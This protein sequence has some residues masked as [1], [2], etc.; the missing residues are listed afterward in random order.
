MSGYWKFAAV[1]IAATTLFSACNNRTILDLYPPEKTTNTDKSIP[2]S[3]EPVYSIEGNEFTLK[4][5]EHIGEEGTISLVDNAMGDLNADGH[6]DQAV[7]LR[8]DSV[9]SGVF[10][11]LNAL[12]NDGQGNLAHVGGE[13]LG[14]RI[15]FDFIRI[16]GEGALVPHTDIPIPPVDYGNI[17]VA[18]FLRE[19][20]QAF[21][22]N[23]RYYIT[24]HWKVDG[25]KLISL[26]QD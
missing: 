7:I 1:F 21:T 16:Y 20:R 5:G 9:G 8:F 22:E 19:K 18:Y 3:L 23:P 6:D 10:Y 17:V 11:Y 25:E 24:R 15:K 2:E 12:L 4:G 26:E 13:F 14:D